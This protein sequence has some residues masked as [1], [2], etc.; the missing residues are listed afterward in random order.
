L[1][2]LHRAG[3]MASDLQLLSGRRDLNPR[4][5]DPQSPP[6][7]RQAWPDRA[8]WALDQPQQSPG[9]AGCRL[10]AVHVGSWNGSFTGGW[11]PAD[12]TAKT[13]NNTRRGID[14]VGHSTAKVPA[15]LRSEP[16]FLRGPEGTTVPSGRP[17]AGP[18]GRGHRMGRCGLSHAHGL[19]G[20]DGGAQISRAPS[21]ALTT[22]TAAGARS[23]APVACPGNP[24]PPPRSPRPG[25]PSSQNE[26]QPFPD[27]C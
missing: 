25:R 8:H 23:A 17:R 5:L 12:G 7:R 2:P 9:I 22:T 3:E 18:W 20:A 16:G 24:G 14:M 1:R 13:V 15:Q 21:S 27:L 10:K 19:A 4:P 26:R 6:G 11:P